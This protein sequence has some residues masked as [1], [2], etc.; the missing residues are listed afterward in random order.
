MSGI[1]GFFRDSKYIKAA[2]GAVGMYCLWIEGYNK[3]TC[4]SRIRTY[5]TLYSD[6]AFTNILTSSY[7]CGAATFCAA[8]SVK[9]A[10]DFATTY[11]ADKPASLAT[12]NALNSLYPG[13]ATGN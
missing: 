8:P 1:L 12:N 2:E 9:K 4:A 11:L 5:A 10:S 6:H 13:V 7:I 3:E